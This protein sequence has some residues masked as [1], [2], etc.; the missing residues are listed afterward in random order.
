MISASA[1]IVKNRTAALLSF[2]Y[3]RCNFDVPLACITIVFFPFARY[4][5]ERSLLSLSIPC[6]DPD[7]DLRC[8][9]TNPVLVHKNLH[10]M[11]NTSHAAGTSRLRQHRPGETQ[12]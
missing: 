11:K 1:K 2:L 9:A 6:R 10:I 7:S 12:A 3:L 8:S 5:P 4:H